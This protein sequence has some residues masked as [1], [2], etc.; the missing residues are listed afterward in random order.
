M[1]TST[2][3]KRKMAE[4]TLNIEKNKVLAAV[5]RRTEYNGDK[6]ATDAEAWE[7][8]RTVDEDHEELLALM[9]ESRAEVVA[10]LGDMLRAEG[11]DGDTYQVRLKVSDCFNEALLPGMLVELKKYFEAAVMSR[12]YMYTNK[13]ESAVYAAVAMS[14]LDKLRFAAYSG[15]TRRKGLPM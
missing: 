11:W 12:W 3:K 8:E 15:V 10:G 4:I 2:H 14:H 1:P 9:E 13:E 7:R 6:N 5:A